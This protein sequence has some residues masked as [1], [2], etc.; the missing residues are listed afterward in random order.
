MG[1]HDF[2]RSAATFI[3]VDDPDK[4]GLVPGVLSHVDPTVSQK[5]YNLANSAAANRRYN[6]TLADQKKRLIR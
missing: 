4:I 5:H 3:A 2:R 6:A 1:L